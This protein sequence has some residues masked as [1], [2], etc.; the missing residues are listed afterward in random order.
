MKTFVGTAVAFLTCLSAGRPFAQPPP[1]PATGLEFIHTGFENASPLHWEVDA[2]GVIHVHLVYDQERSSPN[3]ANGHWHFQLHAKPG[4]RLTLVLHNLDNVWNGKKGSPVS[5]RTISFLSADGRKW[6]PLRAAL[7]PGNRLQL[8]VEMPGPRLYVARLE[9]YRLS[10]LAKLLETIKGDPRVEVTR[11][12]KTVEG[13]DLEIIRVGKPDAPYRVLLRARAHPWE[14]GGNWVVQGLI[15]RLLRDDEAARRYLAR[16]CVYVLPMAN[17]DGVARGR[18]R[19]NLQGKDLNRNWDRPADPDLAPENHALEAWIEAMIRKGQ[20]PD[21]AI[22]FHNDEGGL[23]HIS[24]PGGTDLKRYLQRMKALEGLLRKHT[25][26]TEGNTGEAFH[27]PGTLGEGLLA[28]Y[29]IDA[30]VHE[31]NANWIA[32]LKDYPSGRNWELY[33]EQLCQVFFEY[34]GPAG[35]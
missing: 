25:W 8:K 26:F 34:F 31:L 24:R 16:Y 13:R 27:N 9:P 29:G 4:S 14:P 32:G 17:K 1:Q 35:R 6:Q 30:A 21:L 23:L 15:R 7:L 22:D 3:R 12:G 2:D 5:G 19:F 33:G 10:D 28:R 18:T 20:K 11:I